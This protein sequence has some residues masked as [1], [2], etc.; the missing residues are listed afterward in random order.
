MTHRDQHTTSLLNF[1][2]LE[3]YARF[4]DHVTQTITMLFSGGQDSMVAVWLLHHTARAHA[5]RLSILHYNHLWQRD[6]FF[7]AEH[8]A[9]VSF[10]LHCPHVMAMP[11]YRVDSERGASHWRGSTNTRLTDP[12]T[13]HVFVNGHT[14]SDA[15]ESTLFTFARTLTRHGPPLTD[16]GHTPESVAP[17]LRPLG[18]L[19]RHETGFI[20]HAH[21]LPVYP[22]RVNSTYTNTRA[23][24]RYIILPLLAKM[25]FGTTDHIELP[26]TRTQN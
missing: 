18:R 8:A 9:S 3:E 25:G 19:S 2:C 22:D 23:Q 1:W 15:H 6:N 12:N 14:Q 16:R 10:W 17:V 4:A 13:P 26:G 21:Q 20:V 7:M 11:T 5:R 24:I